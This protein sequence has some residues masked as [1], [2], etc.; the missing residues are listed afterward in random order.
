MSDVPKF[1]RL[2]EEGP[3]EGFQIEPGPIDTTDKIALIDALSR[4]GVKRIQIASFVNP[5]AVPG[6]ADAEAVVHGF[7]ASEDV[8]YTAL[9]FSDSGLKRALAFRDKLHVEGALIVSASDSFSRVNLNRSFDE[10]LALMKKQMSSLQA[11]DISVRAAGVMAAFGCNYSGDVGAQRVIDVTAALM[12][13]AEEGGEKIEQVTL[14]DSMG[15]CTPARTEALVGAIRN[16]WPELQIVLHLHDTRGMGIASAHAALKMGIADFDSTV[17]GLGG[18]PFA[19]RPGATGN[20]ATEELA[21]LCE[22]MGISTGIDLDALID[23]A[24]MAERL[25]GHPL[26]STLTRAGSFASCRRNMTTQPL[27]DL[28]V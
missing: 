10:H 1:V 18:C 8:A 2:R 14:A 20:I 3:R 12:Q 19:G 27:P 7:S 13:V 9:W 22:E 23:V 16:R 11:N 5:K 24:R 15:W 26:P 17:G 4:T 21:L 25:V 28:P 6:W